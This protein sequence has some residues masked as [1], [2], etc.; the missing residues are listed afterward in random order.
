M[1]LGLGLGWLGRDEMGWLDWK[2]EQ[3][4]M[5]ENRVGSIEASTQLQVE[6]R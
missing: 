1:G 5:K 4:K 2:L 3:N 6:P